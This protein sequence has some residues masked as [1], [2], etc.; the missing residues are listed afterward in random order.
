MKDCA[1]VPIIPGTMIA[2]I[3]PTLNVKE[4]NVPVYSGN[5]LFVRTIVVV[6][7]P[8]EANID[9]K[10]N[11]RAIVKLFESSAT[12]N[13]PALVMLLINTRLTCFTRSEKKAMIS[14][15]TPMARNIIEM[16]TPDRNSLT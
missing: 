16:E 13:R 8:A 14:L 3:V 4:S 2:P 15:L 9:K 1:I 12:V 11:T 7:M 10:K 5:R 6:N